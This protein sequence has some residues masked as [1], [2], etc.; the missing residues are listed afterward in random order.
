MSAAASVVP[1]ATDTAPDSARASA[2]DLAR[3][4]IDAAP[5]TP[6]EVATALRG[7]GVPASVRVLVIAELVAGGALPGGRTALARAG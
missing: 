3:G 7:L 1:M 5:R 6:A 4:L 2:M